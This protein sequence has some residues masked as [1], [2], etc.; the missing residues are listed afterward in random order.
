MAD[1]A[2]Q[3]RQK[4]RTADRAMVLPLLGLVLLMPPI[5]MIF[6]INAKVFGIP[7][8]L[9]YLFAVWAFLIIGAAFLAPRLSDSDEAQD[10]D[11]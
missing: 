1:R 2:S 5:A 11:Q 6:E 10:Q 3:Q 8:T 4:R 7:V 9:I